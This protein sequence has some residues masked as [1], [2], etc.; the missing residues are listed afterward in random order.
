MKMSP[1]AGEIL[2]LILAVILPSC[3]GEECIQKNASCTDIKTDLGFEFTHD[4]PDRSEI[5][6]FVNKTLKCVV[7]GNQTCPNSNIIVNNKSVITRKCQD[8]QVK[9]FYKDG[10]NFVR[11]ICLNY[12]V[13]VPSEIVDPTDLPTPKPPSGGIPVWGVVTLVICGVTVLAVLAVILVLYCVCWTKERNRAPDAQL[14]FCRYLRNLCL[15][16][17]ICQTDV[18]EE[19]S[20]PGSSTA[21]DG[22]IPLS[23]LNNNLSIKGNQQSENVENLTMNGASHLGMHRDDPGGVND[24]QGQDNLGAKPANGWPVGS[25]DEIKPLLLNP[26]GALRGLDMTDGAPVEKLS[27]DQG[28]VSPGSIPPDT[29]VKS[30]VDAESRNCTIV[31]IE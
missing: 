8:L 1:A 27:S 4:G 24:N 29:D 26:G 14:T 16:G 6:V 5:Y 25:P 28:Q 9:Y 7:F 22:E 3:L 2:C 13:T 21:A 31:N 11:V 10:S 19:G 20:T 23:N 15:R 30:P 17:K 12:V 18:A